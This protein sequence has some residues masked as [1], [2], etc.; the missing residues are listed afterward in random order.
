MSEKP[1]FNPTSTYILDDTAIRQIDRLAMS[2]V[3]RELSEYSVLDEFGSGRYEECE[4]EDF[5]TTIVAR[6]DGRADCL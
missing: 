4:L 3:V 5:D 1:R 2:G 6:P